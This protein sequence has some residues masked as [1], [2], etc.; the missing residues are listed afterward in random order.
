MKGQNIQTMNCPKCK[1]S[2]VEE[3]TA[4]TQRCVDCDFAWVPYNTAPRLPIGPA[5]KSETSI[6]GVMVLMLVVILIAVAVGFV[7]PLMAILVAVVGLLAGIFY[8]L[9]KLASRPK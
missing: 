2:N 4:G 8:F 3:S 9:A 7:S 5:A 6:G 1:S